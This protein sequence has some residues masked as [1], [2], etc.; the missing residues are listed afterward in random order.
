MKLKYQENISSCQPFYKSEDGLD[1][2]VTD[3]ILIRF[4]PGISDKQQKELHKKFNTEV[5]KKTKIYQKLICPKGG[6]AL[7]IANA[8][9]ETGLVEFSTPDFISY[10]ECYQ[11]I[12]NDT[13]FSNQV[14]CHNTGQTFNDGHSGTNDAD[15]DAPEAWEMCTGSN[16]IV[17]AVIDQ[18]VTSNHPD[19]PNTR[20]VR[21]NGSD[22]VGVGDDNPSPEGNGN[23]GNACAGVIAA[24]MNNDQGIAGIAP[25]CRIMPIRIIDADGYIRD[26]EDAAD[27][28][29]FAVDNG[30]DI[31]SNSWGYPS[32]NPN[33]HPVI[34][35]AIQYAVNNNCIV[36][37]AVGNNARHT[38]NINGYVN[39]PANVDIPGVISVGASDR[40]DHQ[41]DYSPTSDP[42]HAGNQIIDIVAPSHRAYPPEVYAPELGG[43]AGE[44]F[45]MWSIDIPD[46]AGYNPWP[47][48]NIHPPSTGEQL[49]NSGT[50]FLS[51]T[52][53][54]G[55]T[56]HSCPVVAGVAAL[57]LSV[58]SNLSNMDVFN[59]LT[60]TA[61]DV[62]GYTYN[63]GRCNEMGHGRVNAYAAVLEASGG[64]ISGPT[65]VCTSNTT[66]SLNGYASDLTI[67][68]D[69]NTSVLTPIGDD[70]G[71]SYVV[72]AKY[73]STNG[74]GWVSVKIIT[75]C[76]DT[77]TRQRNVWVGKVDG[78]KIVSSREGQAVGAWA[79][80]HLLCDEGTTEVVA[81]YDSNGDGEMIGD[82]YYLSY[83]SITG[84]EWNFPSGWSYYD[85]YEGITNEYI[86]VSPDGSTYPQPGQ[87]VQVGIRAQNGCGWSNWKYDYWQVISCGGGW[88]MSV[89]PNP[90][91]G[92]VTVSIN[93]KSKTYNSRIEENITWVLDVYNI[94]QPQLK[95][96]KTKIQSSNSTTINTSGWEKGIYIVQARYKDKVLQAKLVVE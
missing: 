44:T 16:D 32:S 22:F 93:N 27:G 10:G 79:Q 14:T 2:G 17:I 1:M 66:F 57:L 51:Y 73:S 87:M 5:I 86:D 3:E 9:F 30:A 37:F 46:N 25:G 64:N 11:V 62:G 31:L 83:Q 29:E 33:R 26:P 82:S 71:S 36:I 15:I 96:R 61:D 55:G 58:N 18:G 45:E 7:D 90:S 19:L 41:S 89:S 35:T 75:D 49:P 8:Y 94:N 84:Y 42:N 77:I 70:N 72:K 52:G 88:Y 95:E 80:Y 47:S 67:D 43:I 12:P 38:V 59:I 85:T 65:I 28:I 13:Y 6:D 63:N 53:R 54:F 56:S 69:C 39:F 74:E 48:E 68:W 91:N 50:N 76:G 81:G 60:S 40:Y 78:D 20:Q 34:V 23:H 21:L 24:T 92:M 4:L